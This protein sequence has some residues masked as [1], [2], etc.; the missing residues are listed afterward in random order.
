[1]KFVTAIHNKR[2]KYCFVRKQFHIRRQY[3][4]LEFISR[5]MKVYAYMLQSLYL[6]N[7][8]F[9]E[10]NIP[11]QQ[12]QSNHS[13]GLEVKFVLIVDFVRTAGNSLFQILQCTCFLE[14]KRLVLTV[15][16]NSGQLCCYT[17][18]CNLMCDNSM[19]RRRTDGVWTE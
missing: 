19:Q 12:Q 10:I 2:T 6:R 4:T 5:K 18:L 8:F 17:R 14:R 1:V 13:H 9:T 16:Q 15:I 3:E 11:Y 7:E